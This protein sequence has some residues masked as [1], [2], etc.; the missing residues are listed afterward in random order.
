MEPG[1]FLQVI[2]PG[3]NEIGRILVPPKPDRFPAAPVFQAPRCTPL[4]TSPVKRVR[5]VDKSKRAKKRLKSLQPAESQSQEN[6]FGLEDF[7]LDDFGTSDAVP[8]SAPHASSSLGEPATKGYAEYVD[9]VLFESAGL[10][11][12]SSDLCVVQGWDARA[13]EV[14]SSWYHAQFAI[15]NEEVKVACQ[16]PTR[17]CFHA[18]FLQDYHGTEFVPSTSLPVGL[19]GWNTILDGSSWLINVEDVPVSFFYRRGL[20]N[21]RF[22]NIF[23]VAASSESPTNRAIVVYEGLDTGVGTWSCSKDF[24]DPLCS[25]VKVSAE[26]LGLMANIPH[27]IEG[28]ES[29]PLLVTSPI[30]RVNEEMAVSHLPILPPIWISL[31][32]DTALYPRPPPVLFKPSLPLFQL[33]ST[34]SCPCTGFHRTFYIKG[35]ATINRMGTLYTSCGSF[36]CNVELQPCPECPASR[37][38]FIGPDLREHGIFNYSNSTFVS[39]EL[40]DEYTSSFTLSETPFDAW[41]EF[42]RRRYM[43]HGGGQFMGKDL[44]RSC[45]FAYAHLQKFDDDFECPECGKYP[46]NVIWDGVTLAFHRRQLLSSIHPPTSVSNSSEERPT[47]YLPGQQILPFPLLRKSLRAIS[48][49]DGSRTQPIGSAT[50]NAVDIADQLCAVSHPLATL[51]QV[52][53][54]PDRGNVPRAIRRFFFQVAAEESAIQML[55]RPSQEALQSFVANPS[56]GSEQHLR[57]CP[58]IYDLLQFDRKRSVGEK[59]SAAVLAAVHWILRRSATVLLQLMRNSPLPKNW[60][61][62]ASTI[63]ASNWED[64]SQKNLI[65][66]IC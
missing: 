1:S 4:I 53:F 39:H 30:R 14:T 26:E 28:D 12:I 17:Q 50:S 56:A 52:Y 40:L 54:G 31:P 45:W 22:K 18:R 51:F 64:V 57:G 25:H 35:N 37:K 58:H 19:G 38:Q 11:Q 60:N 44:F 61:D 16:C 20:G 42:I 36:P 24:R 8:A 55:N 13:S 41:V 23:S 2:G 47:K 7:G 10:V 29:E 48:A 15:V 32:T 49:P 6:H 59:Y 43:V 27:A 3:T 62:T 66:A 34:S 5:A 21:S 65:D 33:D 46:D 63:G 9:S